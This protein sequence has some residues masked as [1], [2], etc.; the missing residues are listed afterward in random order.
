MTAAPGSYSPD[1]VA[2]G[3]VT[4]SSALTTG[5]PRYWNRLAWVGF[6]GPQP[7]VSCPPSPTPPPGASSGHQS[8]FRVVLFDAQSGAAALTYT[9]G[10][11]GPCS[12]TVRGPTISRASEIL[13]L[14]WKALG[15]HPVAPASLPFPPGASVPTDLVDWEIRYTIPR[16]GTQFDSGTY[17]FP[18]GTTSLYIDTEVPID[19]P[20]RCNS[21]R[22]TTVS[23]GPESVT[24]GRV[25]HAPTGLASGPEL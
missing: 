21:A 25:R 14:P 10:G 22:S 8:S 17:E 15:Q 20:A 2:L 23:W 7:A 5:L 12:T 16:C 11:T 19:P 9:S 6:V 1:A 4:V 3:R 18:A 24:I 13:S